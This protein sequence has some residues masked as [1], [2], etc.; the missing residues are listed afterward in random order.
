M[1]NDGGQFLAP[2]GATGQAVDSF[3][4]RILADTGG[5]VETAKASAKAS[6]KRI[7]RSKRQVELTM[8]GR[9]DIV[10]GMV[11]TLAGFRNGVSG[12][13]KIMTV[14]HTLSRSGWLTAIT[15]EAAQ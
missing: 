5:N 6:A 2:E 3:Y 14:R 1:S 12:R 13:W 8:P 15:G 9:N 7:A 10:A 11:V 4:E